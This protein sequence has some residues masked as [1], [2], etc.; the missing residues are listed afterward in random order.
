MKLADKL[1]YLRKEKGLS[2]LKLAEQL[3]VS[4]QAISRWEVGSA[5]PSTDNLKVLSDLYGVSVDYLLS[6]T[7][8]E[9]SEKTEAPKQERES[10]KSVHKNKKVGFVCVLILVAAIVI[11]LC[12]IITQI[13]EREEVTSIEDL[14]VVDLEEND[15]TTYTFPIE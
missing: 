2:Q 1:V 11:M 10:E 15:F 9:H 13:R 12:M 6:D 8:E 4:R 7:S 5:I 14:T 3:N